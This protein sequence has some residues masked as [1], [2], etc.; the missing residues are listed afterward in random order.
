[1]KKIILNVFIILKNQ[2]KKNKI[3]NYE[4]QD[5]KDTY[6][7]KN[8]K[9]EVKKYIEIY[10]NNKKIDLEYKFKEIKEYKLLIKFKRHLTNMSWIFYESSSLTPLNLSNF[11]TNNINNMSGIFQFCSSLI[12]KIKEYQKSYICLNFVIEKKEKRKKVLNTID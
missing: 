6:L 7:Y 2:Q 8:E 5:Y 4:K 11:N 1:M 3:I 12:Q 10:L 9:E